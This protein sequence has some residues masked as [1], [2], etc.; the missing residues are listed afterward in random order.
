MKEK[1]YLPNHI[2]FYFN[3]NKIKRFLQVNSTKQKN[4]DFTLF[5]A[6][7]NLYIF[8]YEQ[9]YHSNFVFITIFFQQIKRR[10]N[11]QEYDFFLSEIKTKLQ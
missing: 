3:N 7:I 6:K 9:F 1:K 11:F 5:V 10:K 2:I 4:I 8:I